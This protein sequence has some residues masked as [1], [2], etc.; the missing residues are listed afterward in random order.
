LL[1]VLIVEDD[2]MLADAS[3]EILVGQGYEVSGIARIVAD[4][5]R[6]HGTPSLTLSFSICGWLTVGSGRKSWLNCLG[7]A[8]PV[9]FM[10]PATCHRSL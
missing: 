1:K 3:E 8:G 2:L 7:L 5:S 4:A 6:S 10:S 9:F